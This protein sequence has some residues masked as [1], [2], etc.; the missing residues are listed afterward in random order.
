MDVVAAEVAGRKPRSL[1]KVD[2][3]AASTRG[4]P[5]K[6]LTYSIVEAGALIGL[7]RNAS[8]AAAKSGD[9]PTVRI[10]RLLKVPKKPF[11]AMFGIREESEIAEQ[12]AETV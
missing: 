1:T 6:K 9:I 12:S 7:S 2:K 3:K 10:G 8:Y 4:P 11:L 5:S